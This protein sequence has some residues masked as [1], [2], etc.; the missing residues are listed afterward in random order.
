MRSVW[1]INFSELGPFQTH[2][3]VIRKPAKNS[4]FWENQ[5][6]YI[7]ERE[8][9]EQNGNGGGDKTQKVSSEGQQTW[10]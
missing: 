8:K 5:D 9:R 4:L 1:P 6:I 10:F 7:R 3:T 2:T